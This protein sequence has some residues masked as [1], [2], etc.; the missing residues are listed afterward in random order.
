MKLNL[1]C[2]GFVVVASH[3]NHS[4]FTYYEHEHIMLEFLANTCFAFYQSHTPE[5][6]T[7]YI[8]SISISQLISDSYESIDQSMVVCCCL[9]LLCSVLGSL[10]KC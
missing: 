7:N 2:L 4:Q 1:S 9:V 6:L 10:N 5:V 8:I 3:S